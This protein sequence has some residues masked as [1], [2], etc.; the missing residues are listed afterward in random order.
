MKYLLLSILLSLS[1]CSKLTKCELFDVKAKVLGTSYVPE[2][3]SSGM[4][5]TT[6]GHVAFVSSHSDEMYLVVI[7]SDVCG[8]KSIDD[9][10]L[11][12]KVKLYDE[13]EVNVR[14]RQWA[15]GT[16]KCEYWPHTGCE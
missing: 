16:S 6:G 9:K 1:A 4:G 13:L 11:F 15:D 8:V 14:V 7:S 3:N 2:I 12:G 10:K 5:F